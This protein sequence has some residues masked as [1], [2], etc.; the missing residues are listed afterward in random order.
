MEINHFYIRKNIFSSTKLRNIANYDYDDCVI[1]CKLV[2]K[3]EILAPSCD[4]CTISVG[5]VGVQWADIV[6]SWSY[7]A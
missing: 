3:I 4:I 1:A 5:I 7:E 2:L 6:V